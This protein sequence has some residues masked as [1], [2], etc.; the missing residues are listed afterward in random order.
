MASVAPM[1]EADSAL[2]SV[3]Y[4]SALAP[5]Y[6]AESA[7]TVHFPV[8]TQ[9]EKDGVTTDRYLATFEVDTP[10]GELRVVI[11]RGDVKALAE[12]L[13]AWHEATQL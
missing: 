9:I 11:D 13:T 8:W 1:P 10:D 12:R 4:E 3:H 2:A 6:R 7:L 5:H